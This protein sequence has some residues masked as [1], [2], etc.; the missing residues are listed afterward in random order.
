MRVDADRRATSRA[1]GLS[2]RVTFASFGR[3]IQPVDCGPDEHGPPCTHQFGERSHE[4]ARVI[5]LVGGGLLSALLAKPA[6]SADKVYRIVFVVPIGQFVGA[7]EGD[8][9]RD[10]V[11]AFLQGMGELG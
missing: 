5:G 11:L 4:K 10:L 3:V 6:R 7:K 2:P 8:A 9:W 1:A